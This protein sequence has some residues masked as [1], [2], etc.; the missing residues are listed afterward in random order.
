VI[1]NA[2][3][4]AVW[5]LLIIIEIAIGRWIDSIFN[6]NPLPFISTIIGVAVL[7]VSGY[8]SGV[9]GK[10]LSTYGKSASDKK[11]GELDRLVKE[12]PYSCMRHPMHMFLSLIPIGIGLILA[13]PS[14]VALLGP[15]EAAA[16]LYM[17]VKID[18]KESIERF[19]G[20]YLKYKEEVPP[21]NLSPSCLVK[22]FLRPKRNNSR[23]HINNKA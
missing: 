21:F 7:G 15:A 18:E 20:E 23:T 17:A 11:F 16:I 19:D 10:W 5:T 14:M 2:I 12:G 6:L 13:S 1:S 4:F 9:T 3:R 8:V 22:C